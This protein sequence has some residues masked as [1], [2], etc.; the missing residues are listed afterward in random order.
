MTVLKNMTPNFSKT[1]LILS[2][3]VCVINGGFLMTLFTPPADSKG[4]EPHFNHAVVQ[5]QAIVEPLAKS[6]DQNHAEPVRQQAQVQPQAQPK[7]EPKKAPK[8]AEPKSAEPARDYTSEFFDAKT[9]R[10]EADAFGNH[11]VDLPQNGQ[12]LKRY[13]VS[14]W[15]LYS[16]SP[17]E[18]Q[19]GSVEGCMSLDY[20][21]A[22]QANV[23]MVVEEGKQFRM[24]H[25]VCEYDYVNQSYQLT[26]LSGPPRDMMDSI[27]SVV[28]RIMDS[29][30][31]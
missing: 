5:Q 14:N 27:Q 11:L 29:S 12:S 26:R 17:Q 4:R 1:H 7:V 19:D 23:T 28:D 20:Y 15:P 6:K 22:M 24:H 13:I 10:I 25:Y 2:G 9:A 8:V 31:T 30:P 21:V 3:M 18:R 16:P